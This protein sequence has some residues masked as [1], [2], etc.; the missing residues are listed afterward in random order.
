MKGNTKLDLIEEIKRDSNQYSTKDYYIASF[1][2]AKGFKL[3]ATNK[4]GKDVYFIFEGKEKIENILPG[5]YNGTEKVIAI[6]LTTAI[7]NIKS[8]LHNI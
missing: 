1:L 7:R 3:V 4:K 5:F 6:D 2:K 8:M